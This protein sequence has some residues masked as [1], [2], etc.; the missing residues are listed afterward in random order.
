MD[1]SQNLPGPGIAICLSVCPFGSG[2]LGKLSHVEFFSALVTDVS[3]VHLSCSRY[4][5][6]SMLTVEK[7]PIVWMYHLMVLIRHVFM[8]TLFCVSFWFCLVCGCEHGVMPAN[9]CLHPCL[10]YFNRK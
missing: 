8:G 7:Y 3:E 6:L 9:V 10:Q 1:T 5:S 4:Q 2:G